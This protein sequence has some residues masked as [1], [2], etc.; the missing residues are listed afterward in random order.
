MIAF[1]EKV[2][3]RRGKVWEKGRRPGDKE[4]RRPGERAQ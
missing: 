3:T 2:K 4:A 1:T